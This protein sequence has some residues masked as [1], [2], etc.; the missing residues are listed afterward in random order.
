MLRRVIQGPYRVGPWPGLSTSG[1]LVLLGCAALIA[2]SEAVIS[3]PLLPILGATA[4]FPIALAT[5]IVN[6]P[7]VASA[8]CGAYLLPR[9]LLTLTHPDLPLPPLLLPAAFAFDLV[10]WLRRSDL[11]WRRRTRRHR[12]RRTLTWPRALMGGAIFGAVLAAVQPSFELVP[13]LACLGACSVVALVS[14]R[15]TAP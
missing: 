15:G 7:G 13:A 2:A 1:A 12:T 8:V 9:T 10:V 4:L 11:Y 6:T 5:R 14:A 3:S